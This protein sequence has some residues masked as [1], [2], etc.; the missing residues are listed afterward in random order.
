MEKPKC[1]TCVHWEDEAVEPGGLGYCNRY[2]P[3][4]IYV[5]HIRDF[6]FKF[7]ETHDWDECGEH[8]DFSAYLESLRTAPAMK[9]DEQALWDAV[10][11]AGPDEDN[12]R[13]V[14]PLGEALDIHP[15]RVERM[16]LKWYRQDKV[17]LFGPTSV[18]LPGWETAV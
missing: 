17:M 16:C 14:A 15:K 7:P 8:Q 9:P 10:V 13:R 5:A 12:L 4:P 18:R 1:G 11:A 2:P 6:R 3:V